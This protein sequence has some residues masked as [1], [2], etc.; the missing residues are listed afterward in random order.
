MPDDKNHA[1][2]WWVPSK[3]VPVRILDKLVIA[4]AVAAGVLLLL[5]IIGFSRAS[6]RG[7]EL[8]AR[9]ADLEESRTD[10]ATLKTK[11]EADAKALQADLK[12]ARDEVAVLKARPTQAT[13]DA[14]KADAASW[15][16][17]ATDTSATLRS[18]RSE[19]ANAKTDAGRLGRKISTLNMSMSS[20]GRSKQVLIES[21]AELQ[22]KLKETTIAQFLAERNLNLT[23]EAL[24]GEKV[25]V[26]KLRAELADTKGVLAKRETRIDILEKEFG[27]IPI[28][29]LTYD[30]AKLKW[31]EIQK[32]VAVR[33]SR[34]DRIDL[35]FRA[36]LVLAGTRYES[37][38]NRSWQRQ[39]QERSASLER[40][41]K[42]VYDEVVGRTRSTPDA[43]AENLRLLKDA[44]RKVTDSRYEDRV[45]KMIQKEQVFVDNE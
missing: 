40:E 35:L 24:E 6:K 16:K 9:T 7:A 36:K 5:T 19:L 41:A 26:R 38:S 25:S 29:P 44:L 14:A 43:H 33:E 1:R 30:L 17:N 22:Q 27:D 4:G 8:E 28:I 10:Y 23:S 21:N 39:R 32:E 34:E 15:K 31:E 20:S 11:S 45:I 3:R 2:G 42:L 18:I 37:T 13:L 12:T